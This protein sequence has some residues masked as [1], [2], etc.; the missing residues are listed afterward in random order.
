MLPYQI[1]EEI[2]VQV[3]KFYPVECGGIFV[4][5]LLDNNSVLIVEIMMPEKFKSNRF[6]FY[7][8]SAFL[9]N[10]LSNVFKR[11]NGEVM[12]LGEWHSHC[13]APPYPSKKDL[14][15]MIRIAQSENVRIQ[16][17]LMLIVAYD[18]KNYNE[19]FYILFENKLIQYAKQD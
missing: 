7:R 11:N 17:P 13:D 6:W 14:G 2:K 1:F 18:G 19:Q 9:N 4:G 5:K 15:S 16:T 12:Y 8:I 10:W 3:A